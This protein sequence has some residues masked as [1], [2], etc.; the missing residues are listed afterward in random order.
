MKC[1][2][3][4]EGTVGRIADVPHGDWD[5]NPGQPMENRSVASES[6]SSVNIVSKVLFLTV[7]ILNCLYYSVKA[8]F[9]SCE[10]QILTQQA[11]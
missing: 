8:V 4:L 2:H 3:Q 5:S 9:I 1:G 7:A 6:S 10:I 11:Q